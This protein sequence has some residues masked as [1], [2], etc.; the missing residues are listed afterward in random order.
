M[1]L[2]AKGSGPHPTRGAPRSSNM[3]G[4]PRF[5][6]ALPES[7]IQVTA[8]TANGQTL[9][10]EFQCEDAAPHRIRGIQ[11]DLGGDPGGPGGPGGSGA[12]RSFG[13]PGPGA[14]PGRPLDDAA[15]VEA[16]RRI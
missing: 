10:M 9:A 7:G 4:D 1:R 15:A 12:I 13:G 2:A 8:R 11:V 3:A 6:Q 5:T 14:T 16:M